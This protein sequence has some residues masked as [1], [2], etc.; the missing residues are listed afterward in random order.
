MFW[1]IVA[2]VLTLDVSF[3]C[4]LAEALI[5][6]TTIAE[7]EALKQRRPRHGALLEM[8][9]MELDDTMSA[10]LTIN[11]IT[12]TLGSMIIG[13][14]VTQLFGHVWLGAASGVM[15]FT[16]LVFSEVLPKN[17]GVAYRVQLQPYV[18]YPLWW[19]RRALTPVLYICS[20]VVRIFIQ[21]RPKAQT[22]EKEI[23]LL[24]ER[25]AKEGTLSRSESNIIANTLSL[26][27]VRVSEIMTPRT[28][29]TTLQKNATVGGVFREFPNIPFARI[30][31]CQ[32]NLDDIVGL[33]RRRDL[34]KAKAN[35]QDLATVGDLMQEI[36]LIPETATV[37]NALQLFLKTHQHLLVAVDEFGSTA[38]V[39]TMED[40]MEHILGREIFE[41]D[42]V[43][44]DMRELAR[45]KLQ[46]QRRGRRPGDAGSG[47][48]S[49]PKGGA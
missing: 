4:S 40:V 25:G 34:L 8:L 21:P 38:G 48:W 27:D 9:K 46:K 22:S 16:I 19:A 30:P 24:A 33:V 45:A 42:D 5:L 23:I 11:T 37:G 39:V 20:S 18:V 2:I 36:S 29:V 32:K 3:V 14:L 17:I 41:K 10:V 7:I 13:G 12:N 43:A 47:L 28:V 44:V 15:A 31:V 49:L 35:D 26:D 6:S 1:L